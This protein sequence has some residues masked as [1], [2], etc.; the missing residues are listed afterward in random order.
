MILP[1]LLQ[2]IL[3]TLLPIAAVTLYLTSTRVSRRKY[4]E[5]ARDSSGHQARI[6]EKEAHLHRLEDEHRARKEEISTLREK[7]AESEIARNLLNERLETQG[8]ELVEIQQ[9]FQL[10]FE[11]L[12]NK[13]FDEKLSS[14]KTQSSESLQH[15]LN[16]LSEN[17]KDFK[18]VMTESFSEEQRERYSL[19]NEIDRICT[20][21]E[22][23]TIETE[24]LTLA[25]KGDTKTQ[26]T[27][28]E[29]VLERI[30]E[31]S[32]LRKGDEYSVQ[33]GGMKLKNPESGQSARPDVIIHL[34]LGKHIIIDSKVSLEPYRRLIEIDKRE[35]EKAH[36]AAVKSFLTSIRNHVNGL[37]DRRYHD[38]EGLESPDFVL[39]F[40]PVEA[41]YATAIQADR[42]LHSYS[43]S[44]QVVLVGPWN[45]F[46]TLQ[47]VSSLWRI[48]RQS[49]NADEIARR[50]GAL[51][52]KFTGFLNDMSK[53]GSQIEGL[54]NTYAAARNKLSDG[55]GNLV[56]QAEM[57][58]E[59][60][61]KNSK[62][63]PSEYGT[64]ET[65]PE[66]SATEA[67]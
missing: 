13:I 26:G 33:G 60:G 16:P 15:L 11:N 4:E 27:W 5:L 45:L 23:M 6:E 28:G 2:T 32:G 37:S 49:A 3:F 54:Q 44:K 46:A 50:G 40:M 42:E 20:L 59:L 62:E 53:I 56:R 64:R 48:Q 34:P 66:E 8:K 19:K 39:M 43:W 31:E 63:I 14:F 18:K 7:V 35:D 1:T 24:S 47:T 29:V 17:L 38:I 52:D 12:A 67:S 36:T 22:K 61:A 51:I 21:N 9:K 10:Q 65:L 57:L 58:I 55:Q 30:L 41:A 25:L